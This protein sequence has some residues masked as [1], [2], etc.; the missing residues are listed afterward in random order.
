LLKQ[1]TIE[2]SVP[3]SKKEEINKLL[4]SY[5]EEYAEYD[6]GGNLFK[7]NYRYYISGVSILIGPYDDDFAS[8]PVTF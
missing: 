6:S 3:D 7:D 2:C 5:L 1:V 4:S 8:V